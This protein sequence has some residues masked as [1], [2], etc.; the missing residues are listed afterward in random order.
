MLEHWSF[1]RNDDSRITNPCK[2]DTLWNYMKNK[3]WCY[4][5][6]VD[7]RTLIIKP[8][9]AKYRSSTERNVEHVI[10][11]FWKSKFQK[12]LSVALF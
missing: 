1:L 11:F 7:K 2:I 9:N 12:L 10:H 5:I 6:K 8:S 4:N 3:N